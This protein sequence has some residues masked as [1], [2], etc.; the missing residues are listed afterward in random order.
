MKPAN[1]ETFIQWLL[2]LNM[3]NLLDGII[4]VWGILNIGVW[5]ESNP[6]F[7]NNLFGTLLIKIVCILGISFVG[8][9]Y[10]KFRGKNREFVYWVIIAM[11]IFLFFVVGWNIVMLWIYFGLL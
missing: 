11:S 3:A 8:W 1:N 4:S 5:I 10:F 6:L 2:I 9:N 7:H